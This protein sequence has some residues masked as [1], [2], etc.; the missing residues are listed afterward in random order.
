MA[1][2]TDITTGLQTVTATGAVTPTAGLSISGVTGD[3]TV[4]VEIISLTA[5]KTARIQLESSTNSF[6]GVTADAVFQVIGQ[7]GQGGTTYTA[8]AYNPTTE[9]FSVR[10]Y[11]MQNPQNYGL[12]GGVARLN[13]IDLDSGSSLTLHGW[14]EQRSSK[15]IF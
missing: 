5:G 2:L 12:A 8:G 15:R 9:K 1:T 3:F 14:L 11:Q 6:T 13:L 10:K 4:C 7:E